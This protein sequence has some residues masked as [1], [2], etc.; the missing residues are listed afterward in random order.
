MRPLPMPVVPVLET[1]SNRFE[2]LLKGVP[3]NGLSVTIRNERSQFVLLEL[4]WS[5]HFGLGTYY[6]LR[7]GVNLPPN[8]IQH[9]K[10]HLP[11]IKETP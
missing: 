5:P 8:L 1:K 6:K 3:E 9:L 4:W 10:K 7:K 11:E 2:V